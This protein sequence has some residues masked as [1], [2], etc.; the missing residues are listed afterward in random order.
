[1]MDI[2]KKYI[3]KN[4]KLKIISLILAVMCWFA[5]SY[6]GDTQIKVSVPVSLDNLGKEYI[7]KKTDSDNVLVAINGP[8]SVI[9]NLRAKDIRIVIDLGDVRDGKHTF[10]IQKENVLIP[11]NIKIE[12]IKPDYIMIEIDR[13]IEKKLKTIVRLDNKWASMYKVKSW[14]PQYVIAEG[15]KETL[16]NKNSIETK[17]IDGAFL[18][19]EE[20]ID[21]ALDTKN[22]IVRKIKPDTIKVILKRQ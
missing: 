22:I 4:L 18:S 17:M 21:I 2:L 6:I 9:K 16:E 20:E 5:V 15:A 14:T 11:K 12:E 7:I 13:V 1:M 3:L 8:V 10:N 19:D